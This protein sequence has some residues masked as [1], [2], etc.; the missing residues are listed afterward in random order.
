MNTIDNAAGSVNPLRNQPTVQK[1]AAGSIESSKERSN[2]VE[3]GNE[4]SAGEVKTDTVEIT[5][6]RISEVE[7][8][9]DVLENEAAA[10]ALLAQIQNQIQREEH[11]Q[12]EQM[13]DMSIERAVEILA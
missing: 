11:Q 5:S 9:R 3:G 1:N 10:A 7:A 4:T 6:Q 2:Q 12:L 13:H 8:A